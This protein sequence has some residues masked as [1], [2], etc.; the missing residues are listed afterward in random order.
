MST[1]RTDRLFLRPFEDGDVDFLLDL[2]SRPEVMR[3]IGDGSVQT[4]RAQAEQRLVRYRAVDD[5]VQGIWAITDAGSGDRYG[6]LLLKGLPASAP[7]RRPGAPRP[8]SGHI[9]IGWHLH[10]DAWGRGVA[11]EAAA[12]VLGHAWSGG[13]SHVLAVTHPDNVASQAVA[14]RIGMRDLGLTDA[15][16][17]TGTALFRVDRPGSAD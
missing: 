3:F 13:L 15:F 8:E 7:D 16:Y 12:A 1:L 9:E 11:T 14:R 4:T 17:D 6:T 2:Y 5:P 10:P